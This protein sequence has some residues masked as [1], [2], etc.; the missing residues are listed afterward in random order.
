MGVTLPFRRLAPFGVEVD[1]DLSRPLAPSE[2]FH[3]QM[4][5]RDHG[6][7]VAHGQS[8][9]MEQQRAL[10][11]HLGPILDRAGENGVMSNEGGGP[12]ATGLAWHSD[13]AYTDH[14]FD[15]LALHALDVIDGASSTCFVSAEVA[16]KQL[17]DNFRTALDGREQDMIAPHYERLEGYTCD[18]PD[19]VAQKRG[20]QPAVF[21]N[22]HNGQ[23]AVW[24]NAMQTAALVGMERDEGRALLHAV[25]ERLYR[26][27]GVYEHVWRKGDI[28]I[29][30]NIALQHMR[31][32]L[33]GVGPRVLQ[34]VIV[35]THGVAPHV[36]SA[37]ANPTPSP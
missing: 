1:A 26:P 36:E 16:W 37:P 29:W 10:C 27:E 35:G 14:P 24:V 15:A 34:R 9:T 31:G 18:D 5:F 3:L 4:L 22:P 11:A 21:T 12:A 30:D 6:L 28:V 2:A 19:P 32:N 17:P 23:R 8:L 25:Y 13:A 33:A 7:I 20:R